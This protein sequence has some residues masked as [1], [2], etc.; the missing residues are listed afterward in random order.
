MRERILWSMRCLILS[1]CK[2]LGAGLIWEDLTQVGV[3]YAGIL[4][5]ICQTRSDVL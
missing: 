1:Q 3:V 5:V 2:D 4:L